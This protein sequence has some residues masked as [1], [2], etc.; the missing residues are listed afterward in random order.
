MSS[1]QYPVL[2]LT[3]G[4]LKSFSLKSMEQIEVDRAANAEAHKPHSHDFRECGRLRA[5][6]LYRPPGCPEQ[7]LLR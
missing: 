1:V 3:E 7:R 5:W 2:S 4:S 6:H